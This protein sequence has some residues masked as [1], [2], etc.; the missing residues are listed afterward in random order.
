MHDE[1]F[2]RI[3]VKSEII[4]LKP[5]ELAIESI[6]VPSVVAVSF[7]HH[8]AVLTLKSPVMGTKNGF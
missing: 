2:R 5:Y 6:L 3:W 4:W 8:F 1:E 7:L